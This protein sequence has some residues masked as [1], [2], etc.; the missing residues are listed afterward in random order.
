MKNKY[1]NRE[2]KIINL[3][4]NQ[5]INWARRAG[6]EAASGEYIAFIDSDDY[7]DLNAYEMAIK[8]LENNNCD[9]VQFGIKLVNLEGELVGE[10]TRQDMTFN[11]SK[12][13]YEYFLMDDTPTWN[14]WDKVYKR[15]LFKN[16]E[17]PKIS[18]LE[19]YCMSAQIFAKT[20]KLMTI[21]KFLY[22]YV[23]RGDSTA[24]LPVARIPLEE[25]LNGSDFV[26]NLTQKNF[27]YLLPEA[28][29][30]KLHFIYGIAVSHITSNSD[31]QQ[32]VLEQLLPIIRRDFN[33]LNSELKKQRRTLNQFRCKQ[34][35]HIRFLLCCPKLY[36]AYL[37]TRLAVKK[38]TGI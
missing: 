12:D 4:P 6:F 15:E 32:E 37:T 17:W 22:N 16:L 25:R 3:N 2:F 14:I 29:F 7:L 18:A 21:N 26:I 23:Q 38:Y 13:I 8:I 9:I 28:I 24:R 1:N 33:F 34:L 31:L 30:R 35:A 5:G 20:N 27:S 11:N 36:K 10:W 19:D